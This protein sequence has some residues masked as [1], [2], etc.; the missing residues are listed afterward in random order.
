MG[1]HF[2]P[3]KQMRCGLEPRWRMTTVRGRMSVA[4]CHEWPLRSMLRFRSDD[5]GRNMFLFYFQC[6]KKS[7][8]GARV[9]KQCRIF[10]CLDR[11]GSGPVRTLCRQA[12]APNDEPILHHIMLLRQLDV[13]DSC[14]PRA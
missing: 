12:P 7:R 3:A 2:P 6:V 5:A 4:R 9:A 8:I 11:K 10:L 14:S 13:L 1:G